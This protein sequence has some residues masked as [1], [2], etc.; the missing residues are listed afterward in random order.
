MGRV[1]TS[2]AAGWTF[3]KQEQQ[4]QFLQQKLAK[5]GYLLEA[6]KR[7][8]FGQISKINPLMCSRGPDLSFKA[9][10]S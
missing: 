7:A 4:E 10:K 8:I 2:A 6:L 9:I 5:N 1:A 3:G